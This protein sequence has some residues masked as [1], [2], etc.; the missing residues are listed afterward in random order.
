M[1]NCGADLTGRLTD[2]NQQRETGRPSGFREHCQNQLHDRQKPRGNF[3]K[4]R[5]D[6]TVVNARAAYP[7]EALGKRGEVFLALENIT[8]ADYE[9]RPGYPMPGASAQVGV[10]VSF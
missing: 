6:L 9:M 5:L 10:N 7:L 8:D 4:D 3:A 1:L 2:L